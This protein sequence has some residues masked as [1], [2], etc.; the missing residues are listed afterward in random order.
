MTHK[1]KRIFLNWLQKHSA[2]KAYKRARHQQKMT[3]P[4]EPYEEISFSNS[5]GW[6]F[7]W[8]ET[9]EGFDFW[10]NLDI[11]WRNWSLKYK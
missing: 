9:S 11:E 10:N 6:A 4:F 7:T 8:R 3:P 5:I 2:L 1:Q